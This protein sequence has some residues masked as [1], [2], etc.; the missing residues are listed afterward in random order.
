M[1]ITE[2]YAIAP[3]QLGITT[4]RFIIDVIPTV[5]RNES[6]IQEKEDEIRM[7]QPWSAFGQLIFVNEMKGPTGG[8]IKK[9]AAVSMSYPAGVRSRMGEAIMR[10]TLQPQS[11]FVYEW[12]GVE[13]GKLQAMVKELGTTEFDFSLLDRFVNISEAVITAA[14]RYPDN[15]YVQDFLRLQQNRRDFLPALKQ[16]ISEVLY[17]PAFLHKSAFEGK[18][19]GKGLYRLEMYVDEKGELYGIA[20]NGQ[21]RSITQ[22][23]ADQPHAEWLAWLQSEAAKPGNRI[24]GHVDDTETV[25][26]CGG[27]K[28]CSD[29]FAAMEGT[30]AIFIGNEWTKMSG[31]P[32]IAA[33]YIEEEQTCSNCKK[34]MQSCHCEDKK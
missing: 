10:Q 23:A 31:K 5:P 15:E 33:S 13:E 2:S 25:S 30:Q 28:G 3:E 6:L 16:D 24:I 7:D 21:V 12:N 29:F 17:T 11:P 26:D 32:T 20:P 1:S 14:H 19:K 34:K 27:S 9:I 4:N 22:I 8:T 18:F